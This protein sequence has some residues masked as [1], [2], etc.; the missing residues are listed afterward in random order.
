MEQR[1]T[2]FVPRRDHRRSPTQDRPRH[3]Q[4]SRLDDPRHGRAKGNRQMDIAGRDGPRSTDPDDRFGSDNAADLVAKGRSK[5][6]F[7]RIRQDVGK[8]RSEPFPHVGERAA[9]RSAM[10]LH[11]HL[12]AGNVSARACFGRERLRIRSGRDRP[13]LARRL[14]YSVQ[15]ARIDPHGLREPTDARKPRARPCY[16]PASAFTHQLAPQ[17]RRRLQRERHSRRLFRLRAGVFRRPPHRTPA[18]QPYPSPTRLLR[19]PH[20]PADRQRRYFPHRRLGEVVRE[21]WGETFRYKRCNLILLKSC[22]TYHNCNA[23]AQRYSLKTPYLRPN[24]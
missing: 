5:G 12:H 18:R 16:G 22:G 24:L 3:R 4:S 8:R 11:P 13:N 10:C 21:F 2:G 23:V 7:S 9:R 14:H 6:H 20:V 19:C 15:A 1:R 17:S